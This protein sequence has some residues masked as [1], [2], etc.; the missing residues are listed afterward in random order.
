MN[1]SPFVSGTISQIDDE[2]YKCVSGID[3]LEAVAPLNYREQKAA[4]FG[5]NYSVNPEF[6]YSEPDLDLFAKKRELYNIRVDKLEDN[7]LMQLYTDVIESY[8]D[9]LDQFKSIGTPE[10][11]YDSLRYYGEPNDKDIGNAN[12]I[13]HLPDEMDP[14]DSNFLDS[15][16]VQARMK[17]FAEAE[18]YEYS[19]K[20]NDSMIANALVSGTTVKINSAAQ[21]PETEANALMHHELGVHLATTL[22]G[23]AQPL[24]IMSLGSPVNTT[25]QE[26]LAILCE[27]LSGNLTLYRLK[28]LALRVLAV[29][30]MIHDKDFKRTFLLLKEG[31]GASDEQAF[32]ITARVY[33]GGGFTK[34]YL[35]LQGFHQMLN[36]HR[37]EPEFNNLLVGKASLE[38]L[39]LITRLISKE[40]LNKPG[41]ISPAIR[42][43]QE[44]DMVQRFIARAIR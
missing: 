40:Y 11:L 16:E 20:L 3:I 27:Y 7:D 32:T 25:T 23:R 34:D 35:Y 8:V 29:Q 10:F 41:F 33:R 26:G 18:G 2:L 9:K 31:N 17:A 1:A 15:T 30:S 38:H 6:V 39:P 42:E 5:S 37:D 36:A 14:R 12:F 4:F 44:I 21:V 13:L 19:I 22:N 43:P 24:K 28:V